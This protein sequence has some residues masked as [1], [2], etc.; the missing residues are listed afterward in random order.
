MDTNGNAVSWETT[1]AGKRLQARFAEERTLNAIDHLLARIDTL[2]QAVESLSGLMRQAPGLVAMQA[3][4]VDE[5]IR[6]ADEKG[7]KIDERLQNALHIA[8]RLTAPETVEK[9]DNVFKLT[10]QLPGLVAMQADMF[11]EA[12]RKADALGINVDRRLKRGL[13]IA[14][15][16]TSPP[17]MEKI[18]NLLKLSDQAPGLI[19]MTVDM[20]DERMKQLN[21]SGFDPKN[22][23]EVSVMANNALTKSRQE[24]PAKVGGIFGIFKLLRDPD[25]QKGIGFLMNFIKHF[26]RNI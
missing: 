12:Y 7:V 23:M 25:R 11:D 26:G 9:L 10:E 4:I 15:K 24:P 22:L 19:A 20:W 2:E 21:E 18:E 3:D 16:L 5:A 8:E 6:D 14:E 17:M 13:A 1:A